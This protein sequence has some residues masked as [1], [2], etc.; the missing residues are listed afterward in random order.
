MPFVAIVDKLVH[1][2][3]VALDKLSS[4]L[5]DRAF[6][7]DSMGWGGQAWMPGRRLVIGFQNGYQLGGGPWPD[8][9]PIAAARNYQ[10]FQPVD[11]DD[12]PF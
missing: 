2:L 5:N 9:Q 3:V 12:L 1:R 6:T 7:I 10:H 11:L 4:A 8:Y